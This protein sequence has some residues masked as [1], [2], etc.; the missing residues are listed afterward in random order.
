ME[1]VVPEEVRIYISDKQIH[2][3]QMDNRQ[4]EMNQRDEWMDG[5]MDGW[6]AWM[7]WMHGRI[8]GQIE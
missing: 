4:I 1:F 5:W 8:D 6:D 2:D 3:R 7:D